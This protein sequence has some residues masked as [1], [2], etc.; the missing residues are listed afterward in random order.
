[1]KEL[2]SKIILGIE[3]LFLIFPTTLFFVFYGSFMFLWALS[4]WQEPQA[5]IGTA[6]LLFCAAA[7][8]TVWHSSIYFLRHGRSGLIK[9]SYKWKLIGYIGGIY[10]ISSWL[11]MFLF[12]SGMYPSENVFSWMFFFGL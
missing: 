11:V 1:M 7:I 4:S 2:V 10:V 6:A 8:F 9:F 5:I 12:E 3:M